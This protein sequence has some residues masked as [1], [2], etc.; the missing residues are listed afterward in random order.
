MFELLFHPERYHGHNRRPPFFEGWYFK[1]V[2]HAENHRLAVIP[3]IFK[4]QDP[5]QHHAFIQILD[6]LDGSAT[7]HRFPAGA[8][9]AA[10]DSFSVQVGSNRFSEK[11][12]TL[13]INDELRTVQGTV[14][15]HNT[16]PWPVSWRSLGI[17]GPYGWIPFMECNHGVVSLDH[18]LQGSL[19]VDGL[20]IDFSGGRGYLEKDWGAAFPAGY[21]WMQ[22]NHFPTE[23]TSFVGSIAIIPWITGAFPGF[24][25]GLWYEGK[26]YRFATYTGAKTAA[27]AITDDLVRWVVESKTHRLEISAHRAEGGLLYGPSRENMTERIGETMMATV[28]LRL[29]ERH[30]KDEG[31][32]LFAETG[33]CA[34]LEIHGDLDR[35]LALQ[36]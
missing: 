30:G 28:D 23:G 25:I 34:G 35:L 19:E 8:F 16:R 36:K 6:G 22:T 11:G 15:L 14:S 4:H 18:T 29:A 26:L 10:R 21:V 31:A 33:R 2:D 24:I 3:A 20:E 32:V 9:Q 12:L 17:M 13:D 1:L 5:V 7:Y 27:L